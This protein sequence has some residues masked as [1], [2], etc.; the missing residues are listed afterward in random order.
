MIIQLS[1]YL[2]DGHGGRDEGME[3]GHAPSV[4]V[5]ISKALPRLRNQF[6]SIDVGWEMDGP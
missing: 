1:R 2:A 5:L 4:E 3:N 6:K